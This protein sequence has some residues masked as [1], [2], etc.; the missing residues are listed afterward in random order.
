MMHLVSGDMIRT[1]ALFVVSLLLKPPDQSSTNLYPQPCRIIWKPVFLSYRNRFFAIP[2][3]LAISLASFFGDSICSSDFM[4]L[5]I[6]NL[7]PTHV[8]SQSHLVR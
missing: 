7:S 2:L 4:F 8:L 5:L 6:F 1:H 3:F